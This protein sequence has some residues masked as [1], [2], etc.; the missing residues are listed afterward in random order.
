MWDPSLRADAEMFESVVQ[1][2]LLGLELGHNVAI[3]RRLEAEPQRLNVGDVVGHDQLGGG[4]VLLL[5]SPAEYVLVDEVR[6]GATVPA[7]S[8]IHI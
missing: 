1:E 6:L 7:L 5:T 8:L 2:G 3:E 4:L